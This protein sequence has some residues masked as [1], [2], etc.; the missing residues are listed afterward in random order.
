MTI[1]S[2][3]D[4]V[5]SL[6]FFD[7]FEEI[8]CINCCTLFLSLSSLAKNK[9]YLFQNM[10]IQIGLKTY[11]STVL[12]ETDTTK[13]KPFNALNFMILRK[14]YQNYNSPILDHLTAINCRSHCINFC[15]E[16][17]KNRFLLSIC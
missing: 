11:Q 2:H 4:D 14:N 1:Q 13:S 6:I 8:Y 10:K 3:F 15:F 9:F 7:C 12:I 5:F 17:T 16:N